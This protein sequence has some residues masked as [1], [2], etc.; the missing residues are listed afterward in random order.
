MSHHQSAHWMGQSSLFCVIICSTSPTD[1]RTQTKNIVSMLGVAAQTKI[2]YASPESQLEHV[3]LETDK[4]QG[5]PD[6]AALRMKWLTP[7]RNSQATASDK[8]P[9]VPCLDNFGIKREDLLFARHITDGDDGVDE[10]KEKHM[11][12][13]VGDCHRKMPGTL[14]RVKAVVEQVHANTVD[15]DR[16]VRGCGHICVDLSAVVKKCFESEPGNDDRPL[17]VNGDSEGF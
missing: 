13:D 10:R 6:A 9:E 1:K 16:R 15:I 2:N 8:I 14:D 4:G 5:M 3:V 11:G 7:S 12:R 17:F